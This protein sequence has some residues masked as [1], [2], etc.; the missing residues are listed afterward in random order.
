MSR[1]PLTRTPAQASMLAL[2]M[3]CNSTIEA[4]TPLAAF[5]TCKRKRS[6]WFMSA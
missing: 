2:C 4:A 3:F 5:T 1:F 6:A